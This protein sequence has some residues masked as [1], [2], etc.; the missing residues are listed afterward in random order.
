MDAILEKKRLV[1]ILDDIAWEHAEC[2]EFFA[3]DSPCFLV[4]KSS[5]NSCFGSS[6]SLCEECCNDSRED[7]SATAF[8]HARIGDRN[9]I[10]VSI[11]CG[12]VGG[13]AF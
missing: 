5:E 3:G 4:Q 11:G 8:G 12:D 9:N 13:S 2:T 10:N 6:D 1:Q 7:I